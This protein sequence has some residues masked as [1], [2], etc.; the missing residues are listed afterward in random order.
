MERLVEDEHEIL[1]EEE[2]S[3]A[4]I[5]ANDEVGEVAKR[6]KTQIANFRLSVLHREVDGLD[7]IVEAGSIEC[8]KSLRAVLDDVP[9][10]SEQP[11]SELRVGVEVVEDHFEGV[12]AGLVENLFDVHGEVGT[13]VPHESCKQVKYLRISCFKLTLLVI[14]NKT[15]QRRQEAQVEVLEVSCL[16]DVDLDQLEYVSSGLAHLLHRLVHLVLLLN[17]NCVESVHVD[18]V[19]EDLL[20]VR[21]VVMLSRGRY[22][23]IDL[24]QVVEVAD[25][26]GL[27]ERFVVL[28]GQTHEVAPLLVDVRS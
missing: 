24:E 2:I 23:L 19:F 14:I 13:L 28:I 21:R 1:L 25:G 5:G 3:S 8:E 27:R 11:L 22:L 6:L 15:R 10:Q 9:D 18:H 26:V 16:F 4:S 12:V 17:E 20:Q 7:H